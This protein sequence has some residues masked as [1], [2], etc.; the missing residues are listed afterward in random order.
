MSDGLR[1]ERYVWFH[2]Q[3]KIGRFPNSRHL[4]EEFE[5]ADRTARRDIEFMRNNLLAPLVYDHGRKGYVYSDASYALPPHWI[6][7]TTVKTHVSHILRKLASI[8]HEGLPAGLRVPKPTS[9]RDIAS[10]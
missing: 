5:V 1:Y 2:G 4:I 9:Y 3:V 7:E 6:S 10:V 8:F